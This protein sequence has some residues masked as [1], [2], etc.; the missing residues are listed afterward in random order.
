MW[1]AAI[2]GV[3]LMAPSS[4]PA[5]DGSWATLADYPYNPDYRGINPNLAQSGGKV[6][7]LG[8]ATKRSESEDIEYDVST[9]RV[10]VYDPAADTWNDVDTTLPYSVEYA[11]TVTTPDGRMWV[12]G[13][14]HHTR[15]THEPSRRVQIYDPSTNSWSAAARLPAGGAYQ[16]S[17]AVSNAAGQIWDFDTRTGHVWMYRPSTDTWAPRRAIPSD[18]G[19]AG[20]AW[21][22]H[23]GI[24]VIGGG[25]SAGIARIYNTVT[26]TWHRVAPMPRA[27]LTTT[28]RRGS[29]GRVYSFQTDYDA[30]GTTQIYNPA[31]NTWS[32]GVPDPYPAGNRPLV[33]IGSGFIS[34]GGQNGELFDRG[35]DMY[36]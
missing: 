20:V 32:L 36:H 5:Y 21:A 1:L 4:A 16:E 28:A 26:N 18:Q 15:F 24:I 35:A 27:V 14:V 23:A 30:Q 2:L 6:Y 34:V 10:S 33:R 11:A 31:T 12:I 25:D 19:G 22:T 17:R 13:G 9:G 8:G 29:D 3:S 7:V